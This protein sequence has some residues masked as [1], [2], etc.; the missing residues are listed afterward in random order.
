MSARIR[1]GLIVGAISLF[2]TACAATFIGVCGPIVPLIAGGVAGYLTAK[3]EMLASQ[4]EGG[5]AGAIAGAIAGGLSLIGQ[6]IAG[7]TS[8]LILPMIYQQMGAASP[9]PPGSTANPIYWLSGAGTAFCIGLVGVV[10]AAGAG[11]AGGY[12]GTSNTPATPP[13]Q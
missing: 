3:K 2:I 9:I 6:I 4:S 12:F 5:K 8:L 13:M 7:I 11:F 1:L 10:L